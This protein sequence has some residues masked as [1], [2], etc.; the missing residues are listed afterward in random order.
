[1][2]KEAKRIVLP[3]RGPELNPDDVKITLAWTVESDGQVVNAHSTP[4][5]GKNP[6]NI[7]EFCAEKGI[8]L[9]PGDYEIVG[10]I[11]GAIDVH[12]MPTAIGE[13]GRQKLNR[14]FGFALQSSARELS[15]LLAR[16]PTDV[17]I[18]DAAREAVS[19]TLRISGLPKVDHDNGKVN[20]TANPKAQMK[21]G[22]LRVVGTNPGAV[23]FEIKTYE[24]ADQ[25]PDDLPSDLKQRVQG[26][27]LVI[28]LDIRTFPHSH[29]GDRA[30]VGL[31]EGPEGYFLQTGYVQPGDSAFAEHCNNLLAARLSLAVTAV[32][33]DIVAESVALS[34]Q[35]A[36][37]LNDRATSLASAFEID[38]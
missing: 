35:L 22:M 14:A 9:V 19:N 34:D 18:L 8:T 2:A 31:N 32:E 25:L 27:D 29:F 38:R 12:K 28:G 24:G 13:Q 36:A 15:N 21:P 20:I 7:T 37:A 6:W 1:M 5:T 16:F 30:A 23:C 17:Q 11:D 3:A 10:D 33:R 4:S 26:A